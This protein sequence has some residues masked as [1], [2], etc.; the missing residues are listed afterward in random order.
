[1]KDLKYLAAYTIPLATAISIFSNGIFTYT[2]VFYAFFVIPSIEMLVGK[3]EKNLSTEE[4]K[5]KKYLKLF[6]IIL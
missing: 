5:E 3:D 2:A 6:D 1:M 4:K